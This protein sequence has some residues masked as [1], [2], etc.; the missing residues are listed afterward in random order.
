MVVDDSLSV[1]VEGA[2]RG[3]RRFL[4]SRGRGGRAW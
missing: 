1:E 2:G 4:V 3:S